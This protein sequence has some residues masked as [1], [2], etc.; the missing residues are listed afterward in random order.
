[1]DVLVILAPLLQ[2]PTYSLNRPEYV[3]YG[4]LGTMIAHEI[5]RVYDDRIFDMISFGTFPNWQARLKRE[6][7]NAL[8]CANQ[9]YIDYYQ[10]QFNSTVSSIF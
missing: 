5:M 3:N 2:E 10:K 9:F 4:S 6:R 1:M 8:G 7:K